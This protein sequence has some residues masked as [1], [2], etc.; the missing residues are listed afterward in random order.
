MEERLVRGYYEKNAAIENDRS[1]RH[2][3]EFA[4]STKLL[5]THLPA[6]GAVLDCGGGPG[7]YSLWLASRGYDVTLFDL[8]EAALAI[9]RDKASAQG[10]NIRIQQGNA[11]DL[12]RFPDAAF[13]T[14]LLMGP[15]YHLQ[16]LA[17]RQTAVREAV[18]VLAPGGMLVASFITR[19]SPLR[20][21]A[22]G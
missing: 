18:R 19:T 12:Q 9:A 7:Y 20:Y 3:M 8:S 14:V 10:V 13:S 2:R 11:L 17:D 4:V 5:A 6:G 21:I 15:L 1:N 16:S 22:Q